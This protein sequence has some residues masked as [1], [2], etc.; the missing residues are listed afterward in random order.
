MITFKNE[1]E[2]GP[3]YSR[4]V[5][6]TVEPSLSDLGLLLQ[7]YGGDWSS[8]IVLSK[9]SAL[10]LAKEIQRVF[11]GAEKEKPYTGTL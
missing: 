11:G 3:E 7:I 1:G 8:N 9:E 4:M 10:Y 6:N 2:G 5:A